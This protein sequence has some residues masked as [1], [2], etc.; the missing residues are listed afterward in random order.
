MNCKG[1]TLKFRPASQGAQGSERQLIE[2]DHDTAAS[3]GNFGLRWQIGR[4]HGHL[5][6]DDDARCGG[7]IGNR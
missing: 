1:E 3:K 6:G 7:P 4:Y 2:L 5:I